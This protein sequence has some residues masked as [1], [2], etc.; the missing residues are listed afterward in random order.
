MINGREIS[1]RKLYGKPARG[2]VTATPRPAHSAPLEGHPVASAPDNSN[3][4]N[5]LL[6]AIL[7]AIAGGAA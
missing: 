6:G 7:T 3:G 4:M 5:A 2:N 1:F